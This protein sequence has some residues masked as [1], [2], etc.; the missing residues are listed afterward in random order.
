MSVKSCTRCPRKAGQGGQEASQLCPRAG[1]QLGLGGLVGRGLPRSSTWRRS[2]SAGPGG[3]RDPRGA[4]RAGLGAH[5]P[6]EQRVTPRPSPAVLLALVAWLQQRW[7]RFIWLSAFVILVF[8]AELSLLLGLALLLPLCWR[9]LSLT[10][11]LRCAV[12]A[13]ILCLGEWVAGAGLMGAVPSS[14]GALSF[15]FL[16]KWNHLH[17]LWGWVTGSQCRSSG[18]AAQASPTRSPAQ[19]PCQGPLPVPRPGWADAGRLCVEAGLGA[20]P[21]PPLLWD[22]LLWLLGAVLAGL[23]PGDLRL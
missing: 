12:P 23:R 3:S 13:G 4:R 10:R 8:R 20:V 5:A 16:I 11:A 15:L 14:L 1:L 22:T 9:K 17:F 21:A 2:W 7:A 19:D 18:S 6:P